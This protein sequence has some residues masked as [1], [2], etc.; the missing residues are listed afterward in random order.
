MKKP[1]HFVAQKHKA[2]HGRRAWGI[3]QGLQ[4]RHLLDGALE[5]VIRAVGTGTFGRHGVDTGNGLGQMPSRPPWWSARSFQAAVSPIFGAPSKPL[6]W[7]A[8]QCLAMISSGVLAP[9]PPA[10][11]ATAMP[12]HSW[13]WTHTWPTGSRRLAISSLVAAV[14]LIAQRA[15]TAAGTASIFLI[16]F[17]RTPSWWLITPAATDLRA[18][19]SIAGTPKPWN[20]PTRERGIA[21][22]MHCAGSKVR[23]CR[24][25]DQPG[26]LFEGVAKT[27]WTGAFEVV[28]VAGLEDERLGTDHQ[29]EPAFEQDAGLFAVVG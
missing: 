7:Q 26:R 27:V 22:T 18:F 4:P 6:P 16:W 23:G 12:L 3:R 9:P 24:R 20:D 19:E 11:A 28:A 5:L 17:T 10:V 1:P 25:A 15:N 8:L 13:P 14:A 21:E 29:L 2:R